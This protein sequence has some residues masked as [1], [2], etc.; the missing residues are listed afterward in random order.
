MKPKLI[1][2]YIKAW[3][4]FGALRSNHNLSEE[5][6]AELFD[7]AVRFTAKRLGIEPVAARRFLDSKLGRHLADPIGL[8][9]D[10]NGLDMAASKAC[11]TEQLG[12]LYA[13]WKRDVREFKSMAV[14]ATDEAFYS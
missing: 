4:F 3:G 13:S 7:H 2:T 12:A 9:H 10:A 11:L 8:V 1:A 6:A 14:N 5:E